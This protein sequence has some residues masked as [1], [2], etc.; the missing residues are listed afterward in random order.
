MLSIESVGYYSSAPGSQRHPPPAGLFYPHQSDFIAF[1]G[2]SASRS[3]L[4]A[5]ER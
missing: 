4:A 3:L 2:N 1:I 5:A